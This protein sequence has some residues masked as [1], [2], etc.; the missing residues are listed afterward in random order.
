MPRAPYRIPMPPALVLP[1]G[2]IRW[3][4]MVSRRSTPPARPQPAFTNINAPT[5][6]F[7]RTYETPS[8]KS[9]TPVMV[10]NPAG[11]SVGGGVELNRV[12]LMNNADTKKDAAFRTNATFRPESAVTSPPIEAPAASMADH[13]A[14]D[15]ALAGMSSS[16]EVTFG[17]V[18]VR[19]GSKKA[20]AD[21][22]TAVTT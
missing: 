4:K 1:T 7:E 22:H 14:L 6:G 16:A 11:R 3:P 10:A 9:G 8:S 5:W 15:S 19:A 20:C 21:T 18:A 12:R 13:V 17:M 2:K